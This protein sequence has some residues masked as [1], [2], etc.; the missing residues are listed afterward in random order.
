ML[1]LGLGLALELGL[2]LGIALGLGLVLGFFS[3]L[4]FQVRIRYFSRYQIHH[5]TVTQILLLKL[6]LDINVS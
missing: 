3:G 4:G 1:G 5:L 6:L 2:G